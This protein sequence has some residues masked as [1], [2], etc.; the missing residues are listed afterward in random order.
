MKAKV[1]VL[2]FLL[3]GK[4]CKELEYLLRRELEEMLLDLND[5]RLDSVVRR[6]IEDRY[7]VIFR[8]YARIAPPQE[9]ARYARKRMTH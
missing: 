9:L 1:A 6:A 2:G 3:S 5:R 4:E 8:L 7:A